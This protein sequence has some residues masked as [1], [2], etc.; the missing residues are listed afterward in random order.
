M[1]LKY[2]KIIGNKYFCLPQVH[3]SKP[4]PHLYQYPLLF[5]NSFSFLDEIPLKNISYDLNLTYKLANLQINLVQLNYFNNL[6]LLLYYIEPK[7]LLP[8]QV[9]LVFL[10]SFYGDSA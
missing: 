5:Y 8:N 3:V 1:L 2:G 6:L 7:Q 4:L 10:V 9:C